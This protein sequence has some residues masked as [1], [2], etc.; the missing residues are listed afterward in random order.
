MQPTE[1]DL[2]VQLRKGVLEYCVLAH[3]ARGPSY[4]HQIAEDLGGDELFASAG[5]LY[6]LLARLRK[7]GWVDTRWEESPRGA[8]RRYYT[9]T[10]A[11]RESLRTFTSVWQRF[12]A[13]VSHELR[14]CHDIEN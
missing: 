3:L 8:A 14:D 9:L 7:Q 12:S 1:A 13:A 6:P 4:G 10:A 2:L 11:G 5:S